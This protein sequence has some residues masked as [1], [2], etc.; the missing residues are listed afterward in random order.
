MIPTEPERCRQHSPRGR[1]INA[2]QVVQRREVQLRTEGAACNL[3]RRGIERTCT[4][5]QRVVAAVLNVCGPK[6][7]DMENTSFGGQFVRKDVDSNVEQ[8]DGLISHREQQVLRRRETL[9]RLQREIDSIPC[10]GGAFCMFYKRGCET[11][12][13][14]IEQ[15]RLTKCRLSKALPDAASNSKA[16]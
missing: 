8:I 4:R 3:E 5:I 1:R 16:D 13:V 7:C 14:V 12:E 11:I 15:P 9:Q 2:V 10:E 6:T